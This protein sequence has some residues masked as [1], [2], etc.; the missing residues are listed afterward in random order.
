[1]LKS[2]PAYKHTLGQDY[3]ALAKTVIERV[4]QVERWVPLPANKDTPKPCQHGESHCRW[5]SSFTQ[6]VASSKPSNETLSPERNV[7]FVFVDDAIM[8][9]VVLAQGSLGPYKYLTNLICQ[10]R[11]YKFLYLHH[12][13]Y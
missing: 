10:V 2:A 11:R 13:P 9:S 12:D 7:S 3:L 5:G 8:V 4:V 1:M 6:S